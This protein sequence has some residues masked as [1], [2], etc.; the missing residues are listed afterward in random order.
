L[1]E[2][3]QMYPSCKPSIGHLLS[4]LSPLQPRYYSFC[5]SPAKR[6]QKARVAYSLVDI[7]TGGN[8]FKPGLCTHWLTKLCVQ[9][10]LLEPGHYSSVIAISE[11]PSEPI[12]VW[13]VH[14]QSS[15]FHL[16][17]PIEG[18]L[19]MI[20]P[21]TGVAP[22]VG[23]LE[24]IQANFE[25]SQYPETWLFFGCRHPDHDFLYHDELDEFVKQ[26]VLTHLV[27]AFSRQSDKI[28]YV[29]HKL[30]EYTKQ[31]ADLILNKNATVFIC[32]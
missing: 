6:N 20:G 22:F 25:A 5:S 3:L 31:I 2:L 32:G 15:H 9:H 8:Q 11:H 4:C 29:Q 19:I 13:G 16:P 28:V 10:Q 17:L 24:Q 7:L 14:N 18:P 1:Y 26:N 30:L 12:Q 27:T 23:F 21:G